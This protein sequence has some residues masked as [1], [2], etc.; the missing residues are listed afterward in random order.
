MVHK[1]LFDFN[2][3]LNLAILEHFAL[4]VSNALDNKVIAW[5][6]IEQDLV[7]FYLEKLFIVGLTCFLLFL[8]DM[9]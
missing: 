3:L 7:N 2:L 9:L 1:I 5:F 6:D 4:R 8:D